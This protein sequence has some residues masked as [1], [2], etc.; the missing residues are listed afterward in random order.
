MQPAQFSTAL[1]QVD[2][3]CLLEYRATMDEVACQS[4]RPRA[5]GQMG[6]LIGVMLKEP[7]AEPINLPVPSP[8]S[9]ARRA[10]KLDESKL[11]QAAKRRTWQYK[12]IAQLK[13]EFYQASSTVP[14]FV[15][16]QKNERGL[17]GRFALSL[18]R[19]L[20]NNTKA[21]KNVEQALKAAR[22]GGVSV[23]TITP[24]SIVGA[25]GMALGAVLVQNIPLL[26]LVGAPVI[27][28]VVVILYTV[29]ID[30]FCTW[31]AEGLYLD[32]K[33]G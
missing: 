22:K 16:D 4:N 12:A 6:R 14:Q 20:C 26:G 29:G 30:A 25:G 28:A 24:E 9:N 3:L 21:R 32:P 23:P 8:V 10:W 2:Y 18:G 1:R 13:Q 11:N 17:F 19:Y 33:D 15:I 31:L 7:F 27:A 5:V